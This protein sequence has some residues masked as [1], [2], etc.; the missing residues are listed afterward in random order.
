MH[1]YA[2][3][4][5]RSILMAHMSKYPLMRPADAVK[6]IYQNEFGGGHMICDADASL[7]RLK[8][9]HASVHHDISAP[10]FE[11]IGNGMVRVM[12]TAIDTRKYPLERLNSDFI[13]S[14]AHHRG[15]TAA[16]LCKLKTLRRV[17]DDGVFGFSG[18][19]LDKYLSE[20]AD[21]GYPPVSH[22]PEY[23]E[24]YNP[25]YRVIMSSCIE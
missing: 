20:Y 10:L 4:E 9:E 23:R 1:T 14:A 2:D 3:S 7:L 11:D 19:E 18:A 17:T 6:L 8:S 22:S 21:L 24:A 16:F 15:D 13:F 25:A 5:L 12:L